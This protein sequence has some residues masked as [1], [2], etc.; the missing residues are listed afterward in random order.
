MRMMG[1]I[2]M[3]KESLERELYTGR[4]DDG[5][6]DLCI[7]IGL[8]AIGL[9]W[10]VGQVALTGAVPALMIPVWLGLRKRITEPRTGRVEFSGGRRRTERTGLLAALGGGIGALVL[11][12]AAVVWVRGGAADEEAGVALALAPLIPALIVGLGLV[13]V[14]ALIG[15]RR[16]VGY[17]VALVALAALVSRWSAEPG[18]SL[19]LGGGL[20]CL[21][22][23]GLVARF[24]A[25][26]P[27]L[28]RE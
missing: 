24:V 25:T 27:D 28:E 5:V 6:L 4:F 16:F 18:F 14:S 1:T 2:D 9:M 26:H 22:A 20:L 7:G 15:A 10:L 11:V 21:W 13:I 8:L 23:G 19:S 17:A 3:G 12:L